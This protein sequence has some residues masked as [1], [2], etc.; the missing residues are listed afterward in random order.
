MTREE[1]RDYKELITEAVAQLREAQALGDTSIVRETVAEVLAAE[2][3]SSSIADDLFQR[4]ER[5][6]LAVDV[7]AAQLQLQRANGESVD[8]PTV[9]ELDDETLMFATL[10]EN[11]QLVRS[12]GTKTAIEARAA[13]R[14]FEA[15]CIERH[16]RVLS[17]N[18][19]AIEDIAAFRDWLLVHVTK[20]NQKTGAAL[21]PASVRKYLGLLTAIVNS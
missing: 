14:L 13:I 17:V 11:W 3:F 4:L 21:H 5:R 1:H 12:P 8:T 18:R 6:F 16:Q 19:L 7:E 15:W 10:V 2:G 9:P 20:R